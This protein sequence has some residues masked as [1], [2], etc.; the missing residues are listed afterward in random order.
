MGFLVFSFKHK[1]Q[2]Q[3]TNI[4]DESSCIVYSRGVKLVACGPDTSCVDHITIHHVACSSLTPVHN[5]F[6][7]QRGYKG[8]FS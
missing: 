2:C 4:L 1:L 8:Y 5:S 7:L 3:S 6:P